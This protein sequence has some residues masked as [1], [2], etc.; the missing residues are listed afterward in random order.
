M[1]KLSENR[2]LALALS[3]GTV[4][5]SN[6]V[7]GIVLGYFLD[8]WMGTAPW[9]IITGLILGTVSAFIGLYRIMS[10]LE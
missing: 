6:I 10:R 1:L 2:K 5:S 4:L 8:R 9:M 7:G 3:V